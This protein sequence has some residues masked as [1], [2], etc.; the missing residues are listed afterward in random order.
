MTQ[1]GWCKGT[2]VNNVYKVRGTML[3]KYFLLK[4]MVCV[5]RRLPWFEVVM[6]VHVL[7]QL[8]G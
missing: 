3:M 6:G 2:S 1:R 4:V 8:L 7:G 5:A